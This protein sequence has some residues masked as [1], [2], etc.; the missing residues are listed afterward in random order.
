V[1]GV[2][3]TQLNVTLWWLIQVRRSKGRGWKALHPPP[4]QNVGGCIPPPLTPLIATQLNSTSSCR[5]VHSVNN[6]HRSVL[7]IVTQ[8]THFVGQDVIYDV[9]WRVCGEMEFWSEEFEEKLIELW[10]KMPVYNIYNMTYRPKPSVALPIVGDSWVASVR[11]F[12][13]DATRRRVELSCVAINGPLRG[14]YSDTTQLKGQ[15][16]VYNVINKNTTDLLF[17]DWLYAVQLV[18]LSWVELCRYK[19]AFRVRNMKWCQFSN[20]VYSA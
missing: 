9:F 6:C 8:L 14:V 4:C 1:F 15:R 16:P 3:D 19:R 18:Q 17:A 13:S 20:F 10:N 5:H 12:N 7:N 2:V 11:V